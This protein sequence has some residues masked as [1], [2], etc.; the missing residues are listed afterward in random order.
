M[1]ESLKAWYETFDECVIELGFIRSNYDYCLYVN[2]TDDDTIYILVFV[3]DLLI[4]CKNKD[5]INEVKSALM[6]R[7]VMKDLVKI[8]SYIGIDIDYNNKKG[9][10]TLSQQKYIES[11]AVKYN[12]ENA[13]LYDTPMKTNLK[14]EQANKTDE[15]IKYRNLLGELVV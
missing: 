3:D 9:I 6:K 4:S 12:L 8:K 13:R 5:K 15:T 2:N 14:L 10:M 11:L 1:R 7:F